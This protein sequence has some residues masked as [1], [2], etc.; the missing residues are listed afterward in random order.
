[1][2]RRQK[3]SGIAYLG[4]LL[5]VAL[6]AVVA[7]TA[8]DVWVVTRQRSKEAELLWVGEQYRLAIASYRASSPNGNQALPQRLE[9]LLLDPRYPGVRRHLRKLYRDPMT[10]K[11]DWLILPAPEGGIAGVKSRSTKAPLK[12]DNFRPHLEHFKGKGSYG[13]WEFSVLPPAIPAAAPAK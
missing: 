13:D 2:R 3:E 1:M 12:Q 9:D 5:I 4:L 10:G 7:G 8:A 6:I 11:S